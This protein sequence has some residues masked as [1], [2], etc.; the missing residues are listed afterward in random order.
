[1]KICLE[2]QIIENLTNATCDAEKCSTSYAVEDYEMIMIGR[3]VDVF[4]KECPD[5]KLFRMFELLDIAKHFI[6]NEKTLG[7]ESENSQEYN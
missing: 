3:I 5:I 2:E 6:L 4:M 7:G 1:M